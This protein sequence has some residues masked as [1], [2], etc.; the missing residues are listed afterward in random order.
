[1]GVFEE[2]YDVIPYFVR[3]I[4]RGFFVTIFEGSIAIVI[5]VVFSGLLSEPSKLETSNLDIGLYLFFFS[6]FA[7]FE[8]F[9]SGAVDKTWLTVGHLFGAGAAALLFVFF[10]C[11][12][13]PEAIYA[14][15]GTVIVLTCSIAFKS[16]ILWNKAKYGS[17]RFSEWE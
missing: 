4:F 11:S 2:T 16:R 14:T 1:M 3:E 6:I 10:L 12:T 15:I 7:A 9:Y 5:S 8:T 17:E 13:F